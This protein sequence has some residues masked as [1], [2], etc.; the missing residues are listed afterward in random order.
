[1]MLFVKI[2]ILSKILRSC[3]ISP[4]EEDI[5]DTCTGNRLYYAATDV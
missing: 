1:M 2:N 3:R 4:I 5:L